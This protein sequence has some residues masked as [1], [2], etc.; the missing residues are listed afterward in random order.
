MR[1]FTIA[2]ALFILPSC[3]IVGE[4]PKASSWDTGSMPHTQAEVLFTA[5]PSR[6]EGPGKA[7]III[8]ATPDLSFADLLDVYSMGQA[9]LLAFEAFD[10]HVELLVSPKPTAQQGTLSLIFDFGDEDVHFAKDVVQ[11]DLLPDPLEEE[12]HESEEEQTETED[13][14]NTGEQ[15]ET[16]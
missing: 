5:T 16:N 7:Q 6:L 15:N 8:T 1:P 4:L 12:D 9:E 14:Q 2:S 13:Q 3:I 10:D 11:I